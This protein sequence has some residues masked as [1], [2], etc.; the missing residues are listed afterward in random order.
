MS[1]IDPTLGLALVIPAFMI[2]FVAGPSLVGLLL[3]A[4]IL[5]TCQTLVSIYGN[6]IVGNLVIVVLAVFL[7]RM[8]PRGLTTIA[9][10]AQLGK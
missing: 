7:V 10:R 5:G 9:L 6:Q 2:V 8:F 1:S 4:T 3:S